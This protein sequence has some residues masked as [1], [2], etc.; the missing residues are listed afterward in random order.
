[1]SEEERA[2]VYGVAFCGY[3]VRKCD[4]WSLTGWPTL[5]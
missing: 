1:V 4:S 2:H 5:A 3:T